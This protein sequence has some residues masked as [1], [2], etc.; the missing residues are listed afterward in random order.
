MKSSWN[1]WSALC[2]VISVGLGLLLSELVAG[3]L[4]P[5]VSALTAV[6]GV[7]IDALPPGVKD[8]AIS[9]FGTS[10]KTVFL[11]AMC[12]IVVLLAGLAG[13]LELRKKNWGQVGVGIF[14]VLGVLA[15]LS[16]AQAAPVALLSPLVAAVVG[17]LL[18]RIS[19]AKLRGWQAAPAAANG[20]RA[21][22]RTVTRS[23][24]GLLLAALATA[25]LR[26]S[27][28]AYQGARDKL[29]LPVPANPAPAIPASARLPVPGISDLVT[30]N[31]QF[32]RI[33]TALSVPVVNP[34]DWQLKVTG[35]VDREVTL[36]LSELLSQPMVERYVTIACVSN[37][38][39]GD[40]IGNAR[41][42]GWPVRE[43]LARAGV[44][45][46]A[47]MVLSRSTDGFTAS[48]P[49]EAM[50]D[51]RDALIAV[52]MNGEFLPL[53]HGFPARLIVPGLY[54]YVSATKWLTELKVT[55]FAA[56]V[57]YWSTRGWSDHGPIKQSSRID[58]PR[59]GASVS[60]GKV[61]FAGMAWAQGK[62]I[63]KVEVKLDGGGWQPAQLAT[64]ISKDSWLQWR[65]ELQLASGQHQVQ[66]RST[67]GSGVLQS[68]DSAPPAPDGSSGYHQISVTAS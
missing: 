63:S 59:Q 27:Q 50:T 28:A 21:F 37:E 24:L 52:A 19:V 1:W 7:V 48:T 26:G 40:L 33:D 17:I 20:R 41:W 57:A 49:L 6:G 56:D 14:G 42:L 13:V 44:K 60:A 67:D 61:V 22:L 55:T 43:L 29:L 12:V 62:G 34:D 45:S 54:G 65:A 58:T 15:V 4:S 16:R 9:L 25:A 36:N 35:L 68:A 32:Y 39:G 10:D 23:G 46:G 2:G 53:E 38:V 47:D 51:Q 30:G 18:L 66:V 3:F 11:L 8:W 5:S 31:Q 64:G